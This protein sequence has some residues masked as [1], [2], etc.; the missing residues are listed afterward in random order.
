MQDPSKPIWFDKAKEPQT[1]D[2]PKSK[3]SIFVATPTHSVMCL[4]II[5]K[6]SLEFQNFV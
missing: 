2:K 3:F 6:A 4:F 1:K 5:F